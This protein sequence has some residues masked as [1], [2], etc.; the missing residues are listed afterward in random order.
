MAIIK[1]EGFS[2]YTKFPED[3]S[4]NCEL[5][6]KEKGMLVQL[7]SLPPNWQFTVAG[8][9]KIVKDGKSSVT[10]V[11]KSLQEKGFVVIH[12]KRTSGGHFG[13]TD[14]TVFLHLINAPPQ[15]KIIEEPLSEMRDADKAAVDISP[16]VYPESASQTEYRIKQERINQLK[17]NEY[18]ERSRGKPY[19][20][21]FNDFPQRKYD[22]VQLEKDILRAQE[23]KELP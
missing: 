14:L 9:C 13:E 12:Q 11:L 6:L 17:T 4:R 10:A 7:L 19:K 15:G 1:P 3:F 20:N 8:L 21:R 22:F 5:S 16:P 18:K 2:Q 23:R